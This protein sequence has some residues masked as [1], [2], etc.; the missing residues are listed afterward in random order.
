M[1]D[2]IRQHMHFIPPT[3]GYSTITETSFLAGN[4]RLDNHHIYCKS[5]AKRQPPSPRIW[6]GGKAFV[7]SPFRKNGDDELKKLFYT[8][9][10]KANFTDP[11][12][13]MRGGLSPA[14]KKS[15]AA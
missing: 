2:E 15:A 7:S 4:V 10:Y 14:A 11:A 3:P 12:T 9:E 8:S 5:P 6:E 13:K 1:N